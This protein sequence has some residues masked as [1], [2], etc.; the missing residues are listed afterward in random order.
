MSKGER[1]IK[2]MNGN[3][4]KEQRHDSR[5]SDGHKGRMRKIISMP[6]VLHQSAECCHQC[7]RGIFL[8]NWVGFH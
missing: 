3:E 7:Q 6:S 4:E 2:G 5:G 1:V 8:I